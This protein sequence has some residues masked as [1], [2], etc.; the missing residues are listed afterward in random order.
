MVAFA[1]LMALIIILLLASYAN[2]F[3]RLS[4]VAGNQVQVNPFIFEETKK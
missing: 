1:K 2:A 4:Q 3:P